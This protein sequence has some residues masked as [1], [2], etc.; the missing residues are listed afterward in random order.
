MGIDINLKKMINIRAYLTVILFA[1]FW[2]LFTK[3][4]F[5]VDKWWFR[6][7]NGIVKI[8]DEIKD[9]LIGFREILS[10][11][12][13]NNKRQNIIINVTIASTS[14]IKPNILN[15]LKS[16]KKTSKM[17]SIVKFKK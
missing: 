10:S 15:N 14:L 6:I 8:I 3:L 1:K 5:I 2:E 9:L 7:C 4:P 17:K 16:L 12:I 13:P 11:I